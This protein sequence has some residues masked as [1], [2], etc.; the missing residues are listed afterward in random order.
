MPDTLPAPT[1]AAPAPRV[2][3]LGRVMLALRL[4]AGHSVEQVAALYRVG[5]AHVRRRQRDVVLRALVAGLWQMARLP[6]ARRLPRLA[7]MAARILALELQAGHGP[8]LAFAGHCRT[9]DRDP[10]LVVAAMAQR[11]LARLERLPQGVAPPA[12]RSARPRAAGGLAGMA[13]LERE[14]MA[15][16][17]FLRDATLTNAGS[18]LRRE[19]HQADA[20]PLDERTT[21]EGSAP[22]DA[23]GLATPPPPL[24]P[25]HHP[26]DVGQPRPPRPG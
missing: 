7:E 15:Y 22:S 3:G 25:S 18:E 9:R 17:R 5:V 2:R 14:V 8:A 6:A 1:A 13:P 20:A 19:R 10:G 24:L 23:P 12:P 26:D 21:P 4:A 11:L 16:A